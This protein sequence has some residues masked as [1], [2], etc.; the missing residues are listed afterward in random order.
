[1]RIFRHIFLSL[2]VFAASTGAGFAGVAAGVIPGA[3][4]AAHNVCAI[5]DALAGVFATLRILCFAG[6]AF[7]L[8]SWAWEFMTKGAEAGK[9]V[10]NI[11]QKG[12][13][14]IIGF[15]LLFS[16]GILTIFLPALAQCQVD[17]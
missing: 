7:I 2:L 10:D 6:A 11:K 1:M 15:L 16:V 13:G 17:W 3:P 14:M 12:V 9:T 5:I 4:G 8:M